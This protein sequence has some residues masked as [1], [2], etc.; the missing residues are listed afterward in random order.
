M[1]H[2][3]GYQMARAI[4]ALE[5]KDGRGG[6]TP[7]VA[8]TAATLKGEVER[9]L[10]A[11]MD[12]YLAKPV[13]IAVLGATLRRWLPH[14]AGDA[15]AVAAGANAAAPGLPQLQRPPPFDE[16][17][18]QALTG[19]DDADLRALL[20]D[21]LASN[22]EDLAGLAT[23]R[24]AGDLPALTRQA[25]KLKGAARIVGA[26]ELAEAA[27]RL[28]QAARSD[29]WGGLAPLA[30]D[31]ATAGERLRLYIAERWPG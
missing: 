14:I 20:A 10:D 3:D 17:V 4:R 30:A 15:P 21:Y 29:D 25:H 1:P 22:R 31:V 27:E 7:I 8:L 2:M 11:G 19:G 16:S 12:D 9:C 18:L 26:L 24:A 6:H 5:A 23:A 28:E 13:A